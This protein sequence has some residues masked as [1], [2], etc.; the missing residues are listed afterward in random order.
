MEHPHPH[1]LDTTRGFRVAFFINLGFGMLELVAG[2]LTNSVAILADVIHVLGH[3]TSLGLAWY[4]EHYSHKDRDSAYTFGYR[5]FSLLG[6]LVGATV[7][8][9]GS[10][11]VLSQAIPRLFSP[12]P[13]HAPGMAAFSLFAIGVYSFAFLRLKRSSGYNAQIAAW[14]LMQDVL[15]WIAIF[16]A[17]VALLF[18][19]R[20]SFLDPL[21]SIGLTTFVILNAIRALRFTLKVLLQATPEHIPLRYIRYKL[22]A[23]PQVQSTHHTHIWSLDGERHVLTTHLIVNSTTTR[24]EV[25]QI[26][27]EIRAIARDWHI[28]DVTVEIEHADDLEPRTSQP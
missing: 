18:N 10:L 3:S 25:A 19:S 13:A 28:D 1:T 17:S 7:L 11:V 6:A 24:Q 15:G 22:E 5:R 8:F 27:R 14:N 20:L 16:V 21:L 12:E 4:L 23:L 26:R 2:L 9:I